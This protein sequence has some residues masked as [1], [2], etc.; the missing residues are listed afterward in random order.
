MPLYY[1]DV[2]ADGR[3]SEAFEGLEAADQA[4]VERMAI[5]G[6]RELMSEAIRR[7]EDISQHAFEVRDEDDR[8]VLRFQFGDALTGNR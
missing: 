1:F 8:I 4:A 2:I 3:R 5:D 6:A 7:G